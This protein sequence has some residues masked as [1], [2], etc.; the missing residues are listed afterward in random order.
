MTYKVECL[1]NEETNEWVL[2]ARHRFA[3]EPLAMTYGAAAGLTLEDALNTYNLLDITDCGA[4]IVAES[5]G[6]V[7]YCNVVVREGRSPC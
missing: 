7:V 3:H 6:A 1:V 2:A 5:S 4:R